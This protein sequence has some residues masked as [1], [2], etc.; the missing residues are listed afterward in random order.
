[1]FAGSLVVINTI[2]VVQLPRNILRPMLS[3]A[4]TDG[5]RIQP[6]R[7]Q[8]PRLRGRCAGFLRARHAQLFR[9]LEV[10]VAQSGDQLQGFAQ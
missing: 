1:M 6:P 3:V 10:F 4:V 9:P 8:L 2:I 5:S 7:H